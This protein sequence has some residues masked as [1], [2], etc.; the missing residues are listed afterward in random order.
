MLYVRFSMLL[1]DYFPK[2]LVQLA[3]KLVEFLLRITLSKVPLYPNLLPIAILPMHHLCNLQLQ[4][5]Q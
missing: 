1:P 4:P 2:T 3:N 5:V